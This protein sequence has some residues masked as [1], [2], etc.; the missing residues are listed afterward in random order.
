LDNLKF[1]NQNPKNWPLKDDSFSKDDSDLKR[2]F[3]TSD[4]NSRSSLMN[5]TP[6]KHTKSQKLSSKIKLHGIY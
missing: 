4:N 1:E 2:E 3:N 6:S 5:G